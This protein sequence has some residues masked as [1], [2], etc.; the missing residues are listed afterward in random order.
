AEEREWVR[1]MVDRIL[2]QERRLRP[3]DQELLVRA[4]Q[5]AERYLGGAVSP[6]SVRWV[7]NQ[8][9]RRGPCAPSDGTV[10]LSSRLQGMPTWVVDYV[11]LHE[12]AHLVEPGHT[13]AFWELVGR[14]QQT[15]RARGYLEGVAAAAD[16]GL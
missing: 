11:L 2:A 9:A 16:L 12:L 15:E 13:P 10:R 1:V 3:S 5:L 8:A 14:Y 6:S 7:D 4:G